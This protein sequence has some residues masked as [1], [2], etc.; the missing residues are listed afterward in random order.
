MKNLIE[1]VLFFCFIS[2]F[3]LIMIYKIGIE[4]IPIFLVLLVYL[5]SMKF[6][7]TYDNPIIWF[8]VTYFIFIIFGILLSNSYYMNSKKVN[9]Y[10]IYFLMFFMLGSII[11]TM[12]SVKFKEN[13]VQKKQ[14]ISNYSSKILYIIGISIVLFYII[15]N[16]D[17]YLLIIKNNISFDDIRFIQK[18]GKGFLVLLSLNL[19]IIYFYS[20]KVKD[21]ILEKKN[22]IIASVFLMLIGYRS[23]IIQLALLVFIAF[24][25][26][27]KI[28][29]KS[30]IVSFI[31]GSGLIS[32]VIVFNYFRVNGSMKGFNLNVAQSYL[33]WNLFVNYSNISEVTTFFN[34]NYFNGKT[35]LYDFCTLLPGYQPN[36]GVVIK[37]LMQKQFS[38][39][40]ISLTV[41]GESYINFGIYGITIISTS[42][43]FIMQYFYNLLKRNG[44]YIG[45]LILN[46]FSYRVVTGG[47]SMA[48]INFIIPIIFIIVLFS[49]ISLFL[50]KFKR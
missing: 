15:L 14:Y 39:E 9:N 29:L 1:K 47:I 49:A 17:N 20:K 44:A 30:I 5:I 34:G 36:A 6:K 19:F 27:K 41:V 31:I 12:M 18:K 11:A 40:G 3:V 4:M 25:Y 24:N 42:L 50:K 21:N 32:F 38:G 22:I 23:L 33:G 37:N 48:I 46:I 35:F 8:I 10:I 7:I 2:F 16:L 45:I 28:S 13:I 26:N 43:G